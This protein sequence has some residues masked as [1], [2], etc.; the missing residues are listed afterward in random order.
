MRGYPRVDVSACSLEHSH[1]IRKHHSGKMQSSGGEQDLLD[2]HLLS[3]VV[4]HEEI[5]SGNFD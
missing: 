5:D 3:A 1:A 2:I 4:A